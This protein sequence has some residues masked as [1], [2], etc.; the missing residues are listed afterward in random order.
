MEE[1]MKHSKFILSTFFFAITQIHGLHALTLD[2]A[3]AKV[4]QQ[5]AAIKHVLTASYIPDFNLTRT[6]MP[7]NRYCAGMSI[8]SRSLTSKSF[9]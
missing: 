9:D 4:K 1:Y 8:S 6:D 5:K 3:K 7:K 2:E